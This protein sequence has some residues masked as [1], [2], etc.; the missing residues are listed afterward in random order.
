L[1]TKITQYGLSLKALGW[2]GVGDSGT[3]N[4]EG[5][6]GN[7]IQNGISC[8]LTASAAALLG[9]KHGDYLQILFANGFAY[10]R[11]YDDTAPEDDPRLDMFNAYAWD[12]QMDGEGQFADVRVVS[13]V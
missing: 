11:R 2:D 4:F 7:V 12:K 5:D 10:I 6:H 8:A 13:F 9:A 3:D 1:K